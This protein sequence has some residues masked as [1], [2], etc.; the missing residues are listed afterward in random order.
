MV[1]TSSNNIGKKLNKIDLVSLFKKKTKLNKVEQ[2][3]I[4]FV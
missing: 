3:K 4:S 1:A 2:K